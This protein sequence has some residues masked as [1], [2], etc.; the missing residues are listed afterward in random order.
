MI[1][2]KT[3]S[4]NYDLLFAILCIGVIVFTIPFHRGFTVGD[5]ADYL[6]AANELLHGNWDII[7]NFY[8]NRVGTF[9]P[10]AIG[11]QIFGFS[12]LITW[13][14]T[15]QFLVLLAIIYFTIKPFS[16]SIALMSC[17]MLGTAPILLQNASVVMGDMAS[18][19]FANGAVLLLFYF[20]FYAPKTARSQKKWGIIIGLFIFYAFLVKESV[21]FYLPIFCFYFWQHRKDKSLD[22]FWKYLVICLGF[23]FSFLMLAYTLK[24]GNPFFKLMAVE[25]G[26]TASDCNY[27]GAD[28]WTILNRISWQPFVFIS[29]DY[30]FAYLFLFSVLHLCQYRRDT[31]KKEL[32]FMQ[33]LLVTLVLWWVGSQG[34]SSYNPVS[35]VHRVW[36]PLLVPMA[37]NAA[38]FVYM[39]INGS[40]KNKLY[41]VYLP[42]L[43]LWG[44]TI[45]SIFY[46]INLFTSTG[47]GGIDNFI[48]IVI[49]YTTLIAFILTC[50]SFKQVVDFIPNLDMMLFVLIINIPLKGCIN[51][52]QYK[53][54]SIRNGE[55]SSYESE[56]NSISFLLEQKPKRVLT[57]YWIAKGYQ[58][59]TGYGVKYP[60][61]N[62]TEVDTIYDDTY[63]LLNKTM[64]LELRK[65]INETRI[66]TSAKNSIPDFVLAPQ[67]YGFS[68]IKENETNLLYYKK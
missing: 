68:L 49:C 32:F 18:T 53:Y 30:S 33:Y 17:A 6:S 41:T 64:Q 48:S 22:L 14:T 42:S 5:C 43:L 66:F 2:K 62:Y 7:H 45:L 16:V 65:N 36:L 28:W 52:L 46:T 10:Y 23:C 63:L 58:I 1:L 55:I 56:K 12:T 9:L 19:L 4:N 40:I 51:H 54:Y 13:I 15:F 61:K 67:D 47:I 37:I 27:A 39:V 60:F 50:T 11:I 38:S 29:Q 35:L 20:L 44:C 21:V 26:P 24:T 59:Y 57:D 25:S 3:L 34:I 8:A 31:S